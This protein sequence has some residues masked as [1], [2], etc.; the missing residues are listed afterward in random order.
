MPNCTMR[1]D[2]VGFALCIMLCLIVL[3]LRMLHK[4]QVSEIYISLLKCKLS[5]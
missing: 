5:L 3:G 1:S 2:V 4:I